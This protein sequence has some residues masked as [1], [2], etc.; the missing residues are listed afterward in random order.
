MLLNFETNL[1]P[2]LKKSEQICYQIDTTYITILIMCWEGKKIVEGINGL[3]VSHRCCSNL[4]VD[5]CACVERRVVHLMLLLL[6]CDN[7]K[8]R[9]TGGAK[10][11]MFVLLKTFVF[12]T[13]TILFLL[14]RNRWK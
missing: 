3:N 14:F 5:A 7:R 11:V 13:L 1:R 10:K 4:R 9:E 6:L 12:D 8:F 2:L